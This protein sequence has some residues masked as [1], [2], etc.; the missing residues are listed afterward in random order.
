MKTSSISIELNTLF[1]LDTDTFL[2]IER[3]ALNIVNW[4]GK[5]RTVSDWG[6]AHYILQVGAESRFTPRIANSF[7]WKPA[8]VISTI[9]IPHPY[10]C[11]V[12]EQLAVFLLQED[13]PLQEA[14]FRQLCLFAPQSRLLFAF[15][16][17]ISASQPPFGFSI[18]TEKLFVPS[19]FCSHQSLQR[20]KISQSKDI[21]H[22]FES[23][24]NYYLCV[25]GES[26]PPFKGQNG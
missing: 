26:I 7:S 18:P 13:S 22:L 11:L 23:L 8:T 9:Y 12:A 19:W 10:S 20:K 14:E 5:L 2:P 6:E 3:L 25:S 16:L 15:L 21:N 1:I 17:W 4:V 24:W